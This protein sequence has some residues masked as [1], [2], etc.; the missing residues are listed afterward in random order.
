[1]TGGT[2]AAGP[3]TEKVSVVHCVCSETG[4]PPVV[5]VTPPISVVTEL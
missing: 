2:L 1:M 3:V 4:T 5:V